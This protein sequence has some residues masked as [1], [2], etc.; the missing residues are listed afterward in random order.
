MTLLWVRLPGRLDALMNR[1]ATAADIQ[2]HIAAAAMHEKRQVLEDR[3]LMERIV[4]YAGENQRDA[5]LVALGDTLNNR[6]DELL[7][8]EPTLDGIRGLIRAAPE[9]ERQA[10]Y[11]NDGLMAR[12]RGEV[13]PYGL[14]RIQVLLLYGTEA[15]TPAEVTALVA[16]LG[17]SPTL[18]SVRTPLGRVAAAGVEL[19]KAAVREYLNPR[20]E[21]GDQEQLSR[22]LEQGLLF[23]ETID[24]D[25]NE[26]LQVDDPSTPGVV[27]FVPPNFVGNRGFDVGYYRDRVEVTVGIEFEAI[28]DQAETDLPA[29]MT[30]WENM[31]E[32]AWDSQYSL[33][34][35][36]RTLPIRIDMVANAGRSHHHVNVGSATNVAW[37]RYNTA[38][39]FYQAASYNHAQAPLHEF[40]HMLG[41]PD[42][43]ALSAIDYQTTVGTAPG[44]DPNATSSTADVAGNVTWTESQSIMGSGMSV[45]PRHLNYFTNWLNSK[46]LPGEP[47]YTLV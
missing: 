21:E 36:Q 23:E 29:L 18:A 39:W 35:S 44:S 4:E 8:D 9:A 1:G 19:I 12:I 41:N 31:I 27:D 46:R 7:S 43:Y 45:D 20:L 25:W 6:I 24:E 16:M 15:A 38:N 10:V 30:L 28:D 22:M 11:G 40:G 32:G 33:R 14:L 42:E 2:A 37:P 47:A 34:N 13:T 3:V 26:T 5:L 17:V